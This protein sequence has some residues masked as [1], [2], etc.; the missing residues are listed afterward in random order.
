MIDIEYGRLKTKVPNAWDEL[1]DKQLV[2]LCKIHSKDLHALQLQI[3][4]I[5]YIIPYWWKRVLHKFNAYE[6]DALRQQFNFLLTPPS[7]SKWMFPKPNFWSFGYVNPGKQLSNINM[8]QFANAT[9]YLGKYV[10]TPNEEYLNK[11]M[12]S[13]YVKEGTSYNDNIVETYH[14]QFSKISTERK[15]AIALNFR[16]CSESVLNNLHNA[17]SKIDKEAGTVDNFG[18][19][20]TI[21]KVANDKNMVPYEVYNMPFLEFVIQLEVVTKAK[22]DQQK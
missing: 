14:K 19:H 16:A 2:Y 20:G 15:K 3:M 11:F 22:L 8:R 10:K 13:L 5:H 17:F 9:M 4:M 1:S 21:L 18:W 6:L 12:A 7:F